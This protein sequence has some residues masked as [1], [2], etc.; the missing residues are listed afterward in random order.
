MLLDM[1]V[2]DDRLLFVTPFRGI[3]R[4]LAS[5]AFKTFLGD[6]NN[7]STSGQK[8]MPNALRDPTCERRY[9]DSRAAAALRDYSEGSG[10]DDADGWLFY[11]MLV[12]SFILLK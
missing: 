7:E 12:N 1:I 4:G 5:K 9:A 8:F 10:V 2:I 3:I 6:G 11:I